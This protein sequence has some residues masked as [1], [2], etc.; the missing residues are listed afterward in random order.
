LRRGIAAVGEAERAAILVEKVFLLE[1]EPRAR[2]VEDGG[3]LV[4]GARGLAVAHHDF[5]H[6]QRAVGARRVREHTDRLEN[7]TAAMAQEEAKTE[8]IRL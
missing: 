5:A 6:H 8:M 3:T 2:V 7:A 1:A 4:R